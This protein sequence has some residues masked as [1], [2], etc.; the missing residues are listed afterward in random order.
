[1]RRLYENWH[2]RDDELPG[3]GRMNRFIDIGVMTFDYLCGRA[4]GIEL[5]VRDG[6]ANNLFLGRRGLLFPEDLVDEGASGKEEQNNQCGKEGFLCQRQSA[7]GSA[8]IA[9]LMLSMSTGDCRQTLT[10][11]SALSYSFFLAA[12]LAAL[13][14]FASAVLG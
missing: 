2:V 1:M 11:T 6:F 13:S 8:V 10:N 7:F 9:A 4:S 5:P 3:A 12:E 14:I